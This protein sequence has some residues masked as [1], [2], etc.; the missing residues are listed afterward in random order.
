[1]W[2]LYRFP[3]SGPREPAILVPVYDQDGPGSAGA[4]PDSR[5]GDMEWN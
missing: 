1:M 2:C 4:L 3:A 5:L